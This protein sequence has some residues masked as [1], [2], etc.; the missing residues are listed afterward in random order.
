M[1]PGLVCMGVVV[2]IV[3]WGLLKEKCGNVDGIS[4][5]RDALFDDV[6]AGALTEIRALF[7]FSLNG[8]A[9]PVLPV[10]SRCTEQR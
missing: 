10:S 4:R 2:C 6:E 1:L 8:T 5:P 7:I 3:V 9:S